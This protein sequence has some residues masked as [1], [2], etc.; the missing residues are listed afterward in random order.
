MAYD[1]GKTAIV[2]FLLTACASCAWAESQAVP[3]DTWLYPPGGSA[4]S[5]FEL[6]FVHSAD[7]AAPTRLRF[8]GSVQNSSFFN[9]ANV[10]FWFD[11][12]DSDGTTHTGTPEAVSLT[13]I[14]GTWTSHS[15]EFF[16]RELAIP[17]SPAEL[18]VH[19]F[20]ETANSI[21]GRPLLVTGV[22][23]TVPEPTAM[24]LLA[25]GIFPHLLSRRRR[26]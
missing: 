9:G 24:V 23:A 13:P 4:A 16:S 12:T 21:D 7:S 11:W 26:K 22:L 17:Y 1:T 19:F 18:S 3:A 8:D 15:S 2:V 10:T 5:S 6:A 20:N 25:C 14:M